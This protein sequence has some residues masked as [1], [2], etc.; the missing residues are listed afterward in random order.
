MIKFS[1]KPLLNK[2]HN[3][4]LSSD[5][6]FVSKW[7]L[8]LAAVKK[9]K[10]VGG[11]IIVKPRT[12]QA[13]L[14]QVH[15]GHWYQ[16]IN[17]YQVKFENNNSVFTLN[18]NDFFCLGDNV[19]PDIAIYKQGLPKQMA[20]IPIDAAAALIRIGRRVHIREAKYRGYN[21]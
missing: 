8:A 5:Y 16:Y 9:Y 10:S 2:L 17:S 15:K 13:D 7:H 18:K 14:L 11:K 21:H 4:L 6:K 19:G 12:M 3:S 1:N 20:M